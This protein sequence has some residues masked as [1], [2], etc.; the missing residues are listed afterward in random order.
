MNITIVNGWS[1]DNKGD[2]AIVEG[3]LRLID[4]TAG[5]REITI[6]P[7]YPCPPDEVQFHYRH[8]LRGDRDIRITSPLF[9]DDSSL[10]RGPWRTA[11][12]MFDVFLTMMVALLPLS[13]A[14]RLVSPPRRGALDA[15][16]RADLVIA[17]GGHMYFSNGSLR[18]LYTLYR[19]AYPVMLSQSLGRPT[20]VHGQSIGPVKGA[21]QRRFLGRLLAGLDFLNLRE[22]ISHAYVRDVLGDHAARSAAVVWDT[23]FAIED[24]ELPEGLEKLL[25]DRFV[26]LTVR[27]W[28][29]PYEDGDPRL[30]YERYLDGISFCVERLSRDLHLPVVVVPQAIGPTEMEDDLVAAGHLRERLPRDVEVLYLEDDFTPGQLRALYRRAEFLIATRFHSAILA[31]SACTPAVAVSYHGFKTRGI[32]SMLEL[33]EYVLDIDRVDGASLW[34]MC[35]NVHRRRRELQLELESRQDLIRKKSIRDLLRVID[36]VGRENDEVRVPEVHSRGRPR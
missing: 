29:F 17:K 14:R 25:P 9:A 32:M 3:L 20:G 8:L 6:V 22:P 27:Q 1:D 23:A 26:A 36:L 31:L 4:R 21:L 16:A 2:S 33:E 35:R 5:E 12:R 13:I 19:N 34:E 24:E 15:V 18:S 30:L 7:S 11:R 10:D 28:R